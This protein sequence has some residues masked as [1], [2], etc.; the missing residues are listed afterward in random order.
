VTVYAI[1]LLENSGSARLQSRMNLETLAAT[2]GG[3]ALFPHTI[4]EL[5]SFYERILREIRGQY[6]LGYVSTNTATDGR[7]RSVDIKVSRPGLKVRT[8]KG[9][10]APFKP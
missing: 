6:Q 2:T 4:E 3:M 5:D 7:W 8:R 9:Y 1:G 10:Y